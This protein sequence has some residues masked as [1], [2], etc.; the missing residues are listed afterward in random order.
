MKR[1][2][3]YCTARRTILGLIC[4]ATLCLPAPALAVTF[5]WDDNPY[6]TLRCNLCFESRREKRSSISG[7][8]KD[9]LGTGQASER[10]T[11]IRFVPLSS[12]EILVHSPLTYRLQQYFQRRR[13]L[14]S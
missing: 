10:C 5:E 8:L 11:V 1:S 13:V 12:R 14:A 6:A 4:A 9:V 7:A 3:R 2:P